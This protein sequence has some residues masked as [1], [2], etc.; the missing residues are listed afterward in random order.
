MIRISRENHTIVK[1]LGCAV[2]RLG[3][4]RDSTV[5]AVGASDLDFEILKSVGFDRISSSN[6]GGFGGHC[7]LDL[8]DLALADN[9]YDIVFAH[10]VLHHCRSPHKAAGEMARVCRRCFIFIE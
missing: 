5:L 3:L 2:R 4:S 10:A 1:T 8:E 9:S 6:L 7:P